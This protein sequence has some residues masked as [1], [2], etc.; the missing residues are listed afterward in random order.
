LKVKP[1]KLL[2]DLPIYVLFD[3]EDDIVRFAA[4]VNTIL[5]GK[6]KVKYEVLGT[7]A[8]QIIGLFYI[9]RTPEYQELREFVLQYLADKEEMPEEKTARELEEDLIE[10]QR[11]PTDGDY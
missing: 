1:K 3:E 5:H 9:D 11:A 4:N 10:L 7:H 2:I 6:K 8:R